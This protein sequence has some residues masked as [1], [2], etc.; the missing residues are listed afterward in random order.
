MTRIFRK[1]SLRGYPCS[2]FR[3][4]DFNLALPPMVDYYGPTFCR[5]TR[6]GLLV[7]VPSFSVVTMLLLNSFIDKWLESDRQLI[8]LALLP[9]SAGIFLFVQAYLLVFTVYCF[10]DEDWPINAK[11]IAIIDQRFQGKNGFRWLGIRAPMELIEGEL[12]F[13]FGWSTIEN[14]LDLCLSYL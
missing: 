7:S 11:A 2:W 12:V 5:R 13:S 6:S 3:P 10:W 9:S 4:F 14:P 8:V 1:M